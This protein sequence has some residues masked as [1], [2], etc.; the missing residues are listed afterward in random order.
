MF[1]PRIRRGRAAQPDF[2]PIVMNRSRTTTENRV[3]VTNR[4]FEKD[5]VFH[6]THFSCLLQNRSL[7]TTSNAILAATER[8]HLW[9]EFQ[10]AIES[11]WI[12]R[13]RNL[14][15]TLHFYPVAR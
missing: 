15:Q 9:R 2:P 14:L 13:R 8:F 10:S 12:Q 7:N 6:Q 1:F 3:T 5:G 11:R 4:V